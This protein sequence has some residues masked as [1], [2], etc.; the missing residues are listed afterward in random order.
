MGGKTSSAP[1][2]GAAEIDLEAGVSRIEQL[3]ARNHHDVD[4]VSPRGRPSKH[5]SNQPFSSITPHGI[6]KLSGSD[7]A[8]PGG[9]GLVGGNQHGQVPPL[10][11]KREF[12]NARKLAAAS[13][14]PVLAETLGGWR[15]VAADGHRPGIARPRPVRLRHYDDETVRR[16]RPL[17]LRRFSTSRPF[18][19]AMRTRKPCV[20]LRWRRLG[21]KVTLMISIPAG[22]ETI[23]EKLR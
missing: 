4:V 22:E 5:L 18:L 13:N 23:A 17:A 21:W 12:E 7:N 6:S 19:V 1:I 8:E 16:F 9:T 10:G 2:E 15:H 14:S 3:T 20:R 11:P